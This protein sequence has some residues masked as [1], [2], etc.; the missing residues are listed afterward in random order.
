ML[1]RVL[2]LVVVLAVVALWWVSGLG[3]PRSDPRQFFTEEQIQRARDYQSPRQLAYL[4]RTLIGLAVLAILAFTPAGDWFLR[5]FRGLSWPFAALGGIAV[6][7]GVVVLAQLPF[8]F[9]SGYLHERAWGFSR[10]SALGW[11]GDWGRGLGIEL[12][13]GAV[14]FLG[15]SW[16]VRLFPRGWPLAVALSGAALVVALSFLYPVVVEPVFNKFTPLEDRALTEELKGLAAR[17]GVPVRDVLVA[18]ASRRTSKENA[19]VSGFGSTRR[20]VVYDTLLEKADPEEVTL[21]VAHELGHRRRHHVELFTAIGAAAAVG[22]VLVLWLL[23]RSPA[24]LSWARASGVADVRLLPFLFLVITSLTLIT[25]PSA[26]WISR[27]YEEQAD[28]FALELTGE[29]DAYIR[30]EVGLAV[31]NL[32]ELDPGPIA[33]RF[34]FTHPAPAERIGFAFDEAKES[35]EQVGALP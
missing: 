4:G 26:N 6:V 19:Y 23:V 21:V 17:A 24:V 1:K 13:I 8:S 3:R 12:V 15:F 18:D 2:V 32:S 11:F 5:P 9:W 35:P 28:R 34:L 22:A 7:V 25:Q 20:L 30:T 10:Q 16:L 14:A 33:Y 31:R 29:R 27:R